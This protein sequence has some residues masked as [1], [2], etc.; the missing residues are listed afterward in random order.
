MSTLTELLD[1]INWESLPAETRPIA[2]MLTDGFTQKE[3]AA[4]LGRKQDWVSARVRE[5]RAAIVEQAL[6]L[7]LSDELRE[8]LGETAGAASGTSSSRRTGGLTGT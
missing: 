4:Q 1:L 6:D 8:A 5:L 7:E 3:I 2:R